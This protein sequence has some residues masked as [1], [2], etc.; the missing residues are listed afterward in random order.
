MKKFKFRLEKLLDVRIKKEEESIR[1]FKE[2]QREKDAT[3]RRL[4]ILNEDYKK[5]KSK[6]LEGS[7]VERK[8]VNNY[9]N[10]LDDN[11]SNTRL[12]LS[13]NNKVLEEKRQE[14]KTKQIERKTVEIL[15]D[16]QK[17]AYEKE[18]NL[19]EQKNND[20]FALYG[21]IRNYKNNLK[22]GENDGNS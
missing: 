15:K 19:V 4:N 9:L 7:I 17:A 20:E 16:K 8:I 1:F 18:I 10:A 22:G 21:F 12:K 11:I 13:E 2:A 3:E 6:V 14:L 5:Y